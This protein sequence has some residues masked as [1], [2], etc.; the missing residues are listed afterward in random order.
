VAEA[1]Q[2]YGDAVH[3][4]TPL[5]REVSEYFEGWLADARERKKRESERKGDALELEDISPDEEDLDAW[6]QWYDYLMSLHEENGTT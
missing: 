2:I 3:K 4:P 1:V 5:E 6:G